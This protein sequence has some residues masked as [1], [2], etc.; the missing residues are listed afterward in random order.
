MRAVK[1]KIQFNESTNVVAFE[2]GLCLNDNEAIMYCH[3]KDMVLLLIVIQRGDR[4]SA[5]PG[6]RVVKMSS[7]QSNGIGALTTL[8]HT[9]HDLRR[10]GLVET[11]PE[12]EAYMGT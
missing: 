3:V 12:V 4:P 8:C 5:D 1:W 6:L 11:W 7:L 9:L 10:A 2:G